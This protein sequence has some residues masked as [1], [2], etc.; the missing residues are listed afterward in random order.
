MFRHIICA[1]FLRQLTLAKMQYISGMSSRTTCSY[2]MFRQAFLLSQYS[3]ICEQYIKCSDTI[4]FLK[5]AKQNSWLFNNI[6][7]ILVVKISSKKVCEKNRKQLNVVLGLTSVTQERRAVA[8]SRSNFWLQS[9]FPQ[10]NEKINLII[11]ESLQKK[12]S[13][14]FVLFV[15]RCWHLSCQISIE[16]VRKIIICSLNILMIVLYL[17]FFSIL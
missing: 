10:K 15:C 1:I 8:F 13:P 3:L 14:F 6:V 12:S 2:T 16:S 17:K 7:F 5:T 9:G 4:Y 11:P